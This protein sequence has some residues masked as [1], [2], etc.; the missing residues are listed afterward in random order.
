MLKMFG[1]EYF[2][3]VSTPMVIGCKLRKYDESKEAYKRLYRSIIGSLLDVT[4]SRSNV[5][6]AVG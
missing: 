2:K 4:T 3:L 1:M 5:M 6:Q